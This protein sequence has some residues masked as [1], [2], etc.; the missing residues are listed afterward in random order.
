[1]SK[2]TVEKGVVIIQALQGVSVDFTLSSPDFDFTSVEDLTI[3]FKR[4]K[5]MNLTPILRLTL[6]DGLT[7]SNNKLVVSIEEDKTV[8]LPFKT[9]Y[10]DLKGKIGDDTV[11][12]MPGELRIVNSVTKL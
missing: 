8:S 1:M 5:D 6:G 7:I 12:I 11:A 10:W 4:S 3:D 9:L 2:I